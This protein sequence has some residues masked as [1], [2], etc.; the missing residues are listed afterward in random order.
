MKLS[1]LVYLGFLI[2]VCRG[3]R[4]EIVIYGQTENGHCSTFMPSTAYY[5]KL[6]YLINCKG[7]GKGAP[8]TDHEGPEGE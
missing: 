2:S 8:I 4:N 7:K 5:C 6:A 1:Q 3:E